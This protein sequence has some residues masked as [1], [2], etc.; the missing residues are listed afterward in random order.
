MDLRLLKAF[1]A[2][3]GYGSISRAALQLRIAQPALTR[4]VRK[5]EEELGVRL[6]IRHRRGVELTEAGAFLREEAAALLRRHEE[7]RE[8][9]SS[10][11]GMA[12][13]SL[14]IGMP[15]ALGTRLLPGALARFMALCPRVRVQ[16]VEGLSGQLTD[17]MLAG[18][19]DIAVMNNAVAVSP[20]QVLPFLVS[21]MCLVRAAR[22]GDPTGTA[23]IS[24]AEVARESLILAS[25]SHTL[26]Q[27]IDAA[28]AVRRLRLVPRLEVDSLTLLKAL[29]RAGLG[30]TLLNPY[31]VAE[32]VEAGLLSVTPLGGRGIR[33]RLDLAVNAE[34]QRRLSVVTMMQILDEAAQD[35]AAS[36][37]LRGSLRLHPDFCGPARATMGRAASHAGTAC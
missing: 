34:R 18:R 17:M 19:L 37:G 1:T 28:F 20:M 35:L 22:P 26:R 23:V 29:V 30:A 9:V 16:V 27:T 14:V 3:A 5:L 32:E 31:A 2:V 8:L 13:G 7:L 21:S 4:Q 11:A 36:E 10:T 24:M 33:W 15:A 25:P 12:T 6:L